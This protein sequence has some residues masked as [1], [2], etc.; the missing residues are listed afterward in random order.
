MNVTVHEARGEPVRV[1]IVG[2]GVGGLETALALHAIAAGLV[3]VEL[4]APEREFTYRPLAVAEPFGL[5]RARTFAI[6]PIAREA[7][8][9]VRT[10]LLS[11]VDPDRRIAF[12]TAGDEIDFDALVLAKGAHAHEAVPGALTFLG[13]RSAEA[14]AR[15]LEDLET[16]AARSV[17]FVLPPGTSWSLPLYELALMTA[18]RLIGRGIRGRKVRIVTAE[19]APLALFGN[20]GTREAERLLRRAGVDVLPRSTAEAFSD[21]ELALAGGG[22]VAVD[23][24][25]ALPALEVPSIRGVPQGAK[26]FIPTDPYGRVEGLHDVYAVGDATWFPIKQGGIATQQADLAATAIAATAGA[27]VELPE[28][29]LVL[30][31]ALLTGASPRFLR[32][33]PDGDSVASTAPL[34]WPPGKIAG[35]Y[36]APLL[37]RLSR[38]ELD[39][40]TL[41]DLDEA[42]GADPKAAE[43]GHREALSLALAAADA[44]AGWGDTATA[45]RWLDVAEQ[46]NVT[47]PVEYAERRARW[48]DELAV[49]RT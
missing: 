35:R 2:A 49:A 46:L 36:L 6:D 29:H 13:G 9:T 1:L 38:D 12:T 37:A 32:R 16:G 39:T 41:A 11:G 42:L 18:E 44:E 26:G 31:G 23:R 40:A 4:L 28:A 10:G 19:D 15:L 20:P 30:R 33:D 24:V 8:A 7:G 17:A 43:A 27:D 25:V 34:W 47:L 45:L 21:G 48:R 3:S 14:F 5:A 22:T